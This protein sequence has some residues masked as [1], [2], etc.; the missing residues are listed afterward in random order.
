MPTFGSYKLEK[1]LSNATQVINKTNINDFQILGDACI[2]YHYDV[3]RISIQHPYS[4]VIMYCYRM[5]YL[6]YT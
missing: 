4:K 3:Y 6:Y 1:S 2:L 5:Q